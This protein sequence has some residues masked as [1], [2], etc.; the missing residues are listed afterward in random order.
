MTNMKKLFAT[1][2]GTALYFAL[3]SASVFAGGY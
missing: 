2:I 1:T 3:W